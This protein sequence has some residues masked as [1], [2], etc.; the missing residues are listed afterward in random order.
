[1]VYQGITLGSIGTRSELDGFTDEFIRWDLIMKQSFGKS[2]ITVI[3]NFNNI[4][5]T[6][7]STF[8]GTHAFTTREEYFGWT[9]DLGVQYKF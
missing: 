4:S 5:N 7:E 8:L 2:G 9:G 3:L 6:A 1:M